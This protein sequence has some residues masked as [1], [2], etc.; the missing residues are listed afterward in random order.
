ML[1]G[2]IPSIWS[3]EGNSRAEEVCIVDQDAAHQLNWEL[4]AEWC[5]A[6]EIYLAMS[7]HQRPAVLAQVD[8]WELFRR[9]L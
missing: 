7:L 5:W 2:M 1:G 4:L 8:N 6:R 3:V 9:N